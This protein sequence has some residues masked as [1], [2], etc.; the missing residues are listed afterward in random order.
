MTTSLAAMPGTFVHAWDLFHW[1]AKS[2][3]FDGTI[4]RMEGFTGEH[5]DGEAMGFGIEGKTGE[6]HWFYIDHAVMCDDDMVDYWVVK[7]ASPSL[8]GVIVSGRI[9]NG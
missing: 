9:F 2:R 7:P 3:S 4:S 6:V 8:R 1:N 5:F